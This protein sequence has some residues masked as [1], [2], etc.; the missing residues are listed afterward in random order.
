MCIFA[1]REVV[2]DNV[3]Q[4]KGK[5]SMVHVAD[6]VYDMERHNDKVSKKEDIPKR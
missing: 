3:R 4:T 5:D 6:I 1:F 2:K